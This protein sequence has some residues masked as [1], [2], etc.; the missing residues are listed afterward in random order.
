MTAHSHDHSPDAAHT[1]A[2]PHADSEHSGQSRI[3]RLAMF[4]SAHFGDVELHM[5][6]AD[7]DADEGGQANEP[8]LLV[9]LD[10]ADARI[11]LLSLVRPVSS[12]TTRPITHSFFRTRARQTV[13]S[14]N[15]PLK[16]RVE[17]VLDMALSTISSLSEAFASASASATS[18]VGA[19]AADAAGTEKGPSPGGDEAQGQVGA[20][21]TKV[22][23]QEEQPAPEPEPAQVKTS[24]PAPGHAHGPEAA[25]ED[26]T[27]AS[28]SASDDDD[29]MLQVHD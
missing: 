27:D 21:D 11:N 7:A 14:P 2:H 12:R 3:Q 24:T 8:S 22:Q 6:D 17:A 1:H 23:N 16:R 28:A 9:R 4:L 20:P 5:P 13:S 26:E 10:E 25:A 15:P 18:E 19:I 29:A